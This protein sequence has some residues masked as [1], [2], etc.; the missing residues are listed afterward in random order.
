MKILILL[1]LGLYQATGQNYSCVTT[2]RF[3]YKDPTC[4]SYYMCVQY[5]GS[6]VKSDYT[7]PSNMIFNP[8]TQV[9]SSSGVC[10]DNI[11]D[12]LPLVPLFPKIPDPNGPDC[13]T[14]VQCMGIIN[15]Y[16]VIGVCPDG[17]LFDKNL[18]P[19]P[20]CWLIGNC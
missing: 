5:S 15:R 11:C 4:R 8:T 10:I 1:L 16:P 19:E 17:L 3:R 7:C 2:G 13:R 9:C 18:N 20:G 12:T 6:Y 14:Y